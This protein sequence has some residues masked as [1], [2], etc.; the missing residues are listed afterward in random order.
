LTVDPAGRPELD[1][2]SAKAG[3]WQ[4]PRDVMNGGDVGYDLAVFT[5]KDNAL[6]PDLRVG[7]YVFAD[8]ACRTVVMPGI[9]LL[10]IAGAPSWRH[11]HPL[12]SDKVQV[13]DRVIKQEVSAQDLTV[14]ARAVRLLVQPSRS[15][16]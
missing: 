13:A 14:L 8:V 3:A 15:L 2:S 12:L 16:M 1:E 6:D 11:C 9:Y 5:V 4:V 10:V 7:D